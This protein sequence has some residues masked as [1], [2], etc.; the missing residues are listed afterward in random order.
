MAVLFDPEGTETTALHDLADFS[1]Q[2][3]LEIGC[4]DGRLTWRYAEAAAHVTAIDPDPEDIAT[5]M[6]NCPPGLRHRVD[7]LVSSLQDYPVRV[8]VSKFDVAILSWS[9]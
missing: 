7:F 8:K 6:E 4:G 2:R 3:V 9:L 1:A 5:A